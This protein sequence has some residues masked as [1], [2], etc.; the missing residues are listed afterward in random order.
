MHIQT[1]NLI[2]YMPK[3]EP[4]MQRYDAMKNAKGYWDLVENDLPDLGFMHADRSSM[5]N[6]LELRKSF[7][8]GRGGPTRGVVAGK[9]A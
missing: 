5:M 9:E 2:C 1:N 3:T 4:W 7:G 8:R 6:S